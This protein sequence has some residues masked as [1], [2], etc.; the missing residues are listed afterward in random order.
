MTFE[1]WGMDMEKGCNWSH[2]SKG[3][4]FIL[5]IIDYFSKWAEDV[6]LKE[7]KTS[8]VIKFVIHHVVYC[9]GV[10]R[11]I[12]HDNMP[13]FVSQAFQIFCSKFR[14]QSASL[15]AYYPATSGLAKAFNKAIDKLLNKFVLKNQ[16]DWDE[17]LGGCLW[18]YRTMVRTPTKATPF[19]LVYGCEA[20][21]SLEIQIPCL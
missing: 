12:V 11:R 17:K 5:T 8:N 15:T 10:P 18:A 3:H 2:Q 14:I 21:L 13:Q 4:H 6:P 9:F 1:I 20:V 16:C 19:F 7:E